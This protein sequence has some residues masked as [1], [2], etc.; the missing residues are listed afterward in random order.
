MRYFTR[1]GLPA[2][3][4]TQKPNAGQGTRLGR[5]RVEGVTGYALLLEE[6]EKKRGDGYGHG[7]LVK[8]FGRCGVAERAELRALGDPRV[9]VARWGWRPRHP[10]KAV[11]AIL[12][13]KA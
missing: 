3:V 2:S 6:H 7:G 4:L 10:G 11:Y 8:V 13:R 12:T 9:N 1:Q 5:E